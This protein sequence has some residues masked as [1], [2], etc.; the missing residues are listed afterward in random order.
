MKIN[1]MKKDELFEGF[2]LIKSAEVRQTRAGKN[3]LAFTFQ[4]DT[5][6]IEGKRWDA[7]PHN[8]E[9][10][11]AGKVVHMQGRR[12]VYNNTPQVNQLTLR[13]PKAGEPNDPADFKEKPPVD[14]KEIRD[15]LSQMIFKI[16][17]SVWQ[18]VVR[19]LY[20]KYDKKF[21]SYPA[22]KTNHHAFE[23][24]LAFHT[25]TMVK[26]AD[27]IGDIYPQ[28]NKSLLFAGIMLHDLAK[29][30]E[31]SGPENT[32][33]TVRGNLIGHI[34]LIDEELTKTLM[35]L[36]IDDSKEEVIVLR[37]VLLSHHGLLEY[38]SPV[39]PKIMEAEI[40]HMIDNLDAEMMMMT[41]AL[42]LVDPGEMSNKIFALEGRSFYKPKLEQ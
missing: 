19:S 11:T 20:S 38:G 17:N 7:Q 14:Q 30:I 5:G 1:Q 24:G 27:A 36:K 12:E 37:H 34:A 8:V 6:V 9:E 28:L 32:E 10:F 31:L 18:R 22:A 3:Y 2:Y 4:D 41:A 33:Y 39:R 15:Y 26:L 29:V 35:E 16:E 21:Y 42:G 23:S 13:L 25:A 40:L